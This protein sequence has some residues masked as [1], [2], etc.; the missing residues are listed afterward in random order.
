MAS[1]TVPKDQRTR[2]PIYL[3]AK[4]SFNLIVSDAN[5][6]FS[7]VMKLTAQL[8]QMSLAGLTFAENVDQ[9]AVE[10]GGDFKPKAKVNL[11]AAELFKNDTLNF[12][13]PRI[14]GSLLEPLTRF[15]VEIDRIT[16][17]RDSH[18]DANT[19]YDISRVKLQKASAKPTTSAAELQK[20]QEDLESSKQTYEEINQGFIDS[21]AKLKDQ[22]I[23]T[24][25]K[26]A[27]RFVALISQY[28]LAIMTEIQKFRA[29]YPSIDTVAAS[30]LSAKGSSS[31]L[32][33]PSNP[34]SSSPSITI[35][36]SS[37]DVA[38]V[39]Q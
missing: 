24:L 5:E 19:V 30:K 13:K 1:V 14:E 4:E 8:E 26:P 6:I 38:N 35:S 39:P 25:D 15:Q 34:S 3:E 23:E 11:G 21:V 20:L 9:F 10:G 29:V 31:T 36:G 12:W 27:K 33:P 16:Q 18:A 22:R 37:N 28:L 32:T 2:D 7:S 17:L